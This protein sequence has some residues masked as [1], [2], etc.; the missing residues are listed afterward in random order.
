MQVSRIYKDSS[1]GNPI[2]IAVTKIKQI[3][4]IFGSKE[5]GSDGIGAA[6]MLK[7]F[8][9]WQKSTDHTDHHDAALLL[10]RENLCHNPGQKRCDTLG[11]AELGRM[12]SLGSSCAIVQDNGL[13]TAFT[14]AHEIGHV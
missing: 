1:I 7:K 5:E 9:R 10:T 13:A 2:S 3:D 4:E 12:C 8:C 11:L 14:I 6:E